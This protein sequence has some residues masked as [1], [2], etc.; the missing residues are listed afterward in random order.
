MLC[1]LKNAATIGLAIAGLLGTVVF[2]SAQEDTPSAWVKLCNKIGQSD[3]TLCATA[4]EIRA[5][6]GQFLA[7]VAIREFS[8]QDK[9]AL[10]V[11]V[12]TGMLIQ[13]GLGLRVDENEQRVIQYAI[14]R[15]QACIAEIE[16][17]DAIIAELKR[18][19][20]LMVTTVNQ[21]AQQ[22]GFPLTLVGFTAALDGEATNPAD[23][24]AQRERLRQEAEAKAAEA[25]QRLIEQQEQATGGN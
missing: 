3:V 4:Q 5:D 7:S 21:Q 19:G 9:K 10:V 2:A 15:P 25:R 24:Q 17:T 12:P 18:G 8:N 11:A 1:K 16:A 20:Q 13:P 23:L 6:T 14:C 22:V